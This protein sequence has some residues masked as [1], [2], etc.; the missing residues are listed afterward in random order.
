MT[1]Q[2][3]PEETPVT[4][5]KLDLLIEL[6]SSLRKDVDAIRLRLDRA[7]AGDMKTLWDKVC[8]HQADPLRRIA[9]LECILEG[10]ESMAKLKAEPSRMVT[11]AEMRE[12]MAARGVVMG[13]AL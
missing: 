5:E 8:A 11:G 6:V 9:L 13:N 1:V 2:T 10:R 4:V 3:I 7:E 12:R